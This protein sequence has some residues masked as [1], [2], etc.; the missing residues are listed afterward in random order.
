MYPVSYRDRQVIVTGG[1]T[2]GGAARLDVPAE[3][4]VTHVTVL[5]VGQLD[6]SART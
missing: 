5:D 3:L 2:G 1:A 6:L 4:D